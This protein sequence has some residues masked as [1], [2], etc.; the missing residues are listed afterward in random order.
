MSQPRLHSSQSG[1]MIVEAVLII[2]L[3]MG[4]T[5]LVTNYFRNN[6]VLKTLVQGPWISLAGMLQNGS[7]GPIK[8]TAAIHPSAHGRHIVITGESP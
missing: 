5:F 1:Q 7:W 8:D 6:E 2:T 3:L 4:A